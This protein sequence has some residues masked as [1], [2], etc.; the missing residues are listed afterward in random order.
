M[1]FTFEADFA[2]RPTLKATDATVRA[3]AGIGRKADFAASLLKAGQGQP[4]TEDPDKADLSD[5]GTLAATAALM[6]QAPEPAEVTPAGDEADATAI[7]SE[8][9]AVALP[10]AS[11]ISA[12]PNLPV[13]ALPTEPAA[14]TGPDAASG[15]RVD[16]GTTGI[17]ARSDPAQAITPAA[18]V[19]PAESTDLPAESPAKDAPQV[20]AS[21]PVPAQPDTTLARSA[22]DAAS[23]RTPDSPPAT[24][25]AALSDSD[26]TTTATSGIAVV[27]NPHAQA[28]RTAATATAG[29][30]ASNAVSGRPAARPAP[31]TGPSAGHDSGRAP[32][33]GAPHGVRIDDGESTA[34]LAAAPSAFDEL[35]EA[36]PKHHGTQGTDAPVQTATSAL[37]G[38]VSTPVGANA[39]PVA[40]TPTQSL[41]SATPAQVV[42]II[43]DSLAAPEDRKDRITVQLDPPEL[44]RV[45]IDFKFDA[46][47]LQHVT[48]TGD[49]PEAMRHLRM[50]HFELVQALERQGLS[51]QNMSF[52]QNLPHQQDQNNQPGSGA[53]ALHHPSPDTIVVKPAIVAASNTSRLSSTGGGLN[54]KL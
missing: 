19:V 29:V 46:H 16:A 12:E 50:M 21:T 33:K 42:D 32:M 25:P 17:V 49:N 28:D 14:G 48:V 47:G 45:S 26:S 24:D 51:G 20:D 37:P 27:G 23:V 10:D 40:M 52:Q 54:I 13:P 2:S 30:T 44:G 7:A 39:A 18:T 34:A 35:V 43:S 6:P 53:P 31:G 41:V 4:P 36:A 8:P 3:P 5:T 15:T 1:T 22:P 38:P 9:I 11:L